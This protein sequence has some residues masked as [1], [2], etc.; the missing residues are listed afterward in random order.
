MFKLLILSIAVCV[1]W[2]KKILVQTGAESKTDF[3]WEKNMFFNVK[4]SDCQLELF[5]CNFREA[6]KIT[7]KGI[8]VKLFKQNTFYKTLKYWE[9]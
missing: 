7:P 4:Q 1:F 8:P 9:T 5:Y 2:S 6:L 3:C